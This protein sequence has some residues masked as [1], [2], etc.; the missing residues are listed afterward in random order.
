MTVIIQ[1]AS[2][3]RQIA[4]NAP[5]PRSEKRKKIRHCDVQGPQIAMTLV[6]AVVNIIGFLVML[7]GVLTVLKQFNIFGEE[8]MRR[9]SEFFFGKLIRD[10]VYSIG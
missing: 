10:L 1:A 4:E 5:P 9:L 3:I 6:E 2:V 8:H 7:T